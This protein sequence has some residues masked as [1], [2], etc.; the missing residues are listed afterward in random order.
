MTIGFWRTACRTAVLGTSFVTFIYAAP[1]AAHDFWLQPNTFS[2]PPHGATPMSIQVGHGQA[3]QAWKL[4]TTRVVLF[5]SLG[6]DGTRD[7]SKDLKPGPGAEVASLHFDRPGTYLISFQTTPALSNLPFIRYNDYAKVEGLTPALE[8]RARTHT[9]DQPGREAY[10]RRCKALVQVGE[11]DAGSPWVTQPLGL[12]LEIVPEMSPYL[13]KADELLPVRV[14]FQGR[15]LAGALVKLT[16]LEFD[17]R[18]L[19]THLSDRDGRAAFKVPHT[20]A[21]LVNVIWTQPAKAEPQAD[22][23]TTFSSLTFAYPPRV[24]PH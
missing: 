4:D 18:P 3:R 12:S 21:W 1:T 17:G 10:S 5:R 8:Y 11:P 13:L 9:T 23:D 19:E 6:P 15:P 7:L 14:Y 16:N 20:G 24:W 2:L 22:F